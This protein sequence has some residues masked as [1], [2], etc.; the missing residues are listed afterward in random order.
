VK[1]V[2]H[3]A[4]KKEN[5]KKYKKKRRW[6]HSHHHGWPVVSGTARG[7]WHGRAIWHGQAVLAGTPPVCVFPSRRFDFP[8]VLGVLQ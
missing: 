4:Q 5:N 1:T 8:A 6:S 2:Q 7:G 3:K